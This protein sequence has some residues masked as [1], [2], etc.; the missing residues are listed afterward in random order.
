[1]DLI[2]LFHVIWR[3]FWLVL[4]V[5]GISGAV[6]FYKV[7]D[8]P[9][10]YEATV[11]I[12]LSA[13]PPLD[14]ALYDQY[15]SSNLR[16]DMT[17]AAN[18]FRELMQSVE[19]NQ[20][21]ITQL[22][23]TA[24]DADYSI[25]VTALGDSNFIFATAQAR[26][27]QLAQEI[28]NAAVSIGISYYGE[29]SAKPAAAAGES[30]HAQ[31]QNAEKDLRAA[32][33]AL[34]N[35]QKDNNITSLE[36]ELANDNL[37]IQ[38]LQTARSDLLVEGKPTS[39]IDNLLAQRRQEVV[40]L[41]ALSPSYA[42]LEENAKQ[43]K[44]GYDLLLSKYQE[45]TLKVDDVRS[46]SFMQVIEPA[47]EPAAQIPSKSKTILGLTFAGSLGLG[48]LLALLLDSFRKA[49][50]EVNGPRLSKHE[51]MA[52]QQV[53]VAPVNAIVPGEEVKRPDVPA[54]T[55]WFKA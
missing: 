42:V 8:A 43:A 19:V 2:S 3:W 11:K 52:E 36:D 14:V 55:P 38:R 34:A 17:V 16:D 50:I 47:T 46:A 24:E 6:A 26:T 7:S 54:G 15:R 10:L 21:T 51:A 1:M 39:A 45:A 32:Q 20:R 27:P 12:Q 40:N 53:V 22:A 23:L 9:A 37:L 48:V 29:V 31:L 13:P 18:N 5:V 33:D 28:A 49:R 44:A 41:Q 35:F 25:Q 30:I 4:V